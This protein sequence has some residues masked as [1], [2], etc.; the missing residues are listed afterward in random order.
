MHFEQLTTAANQTHGQELKH[1]DRQR[2]VKQ[3]HAMTEPTF[4]PTGAVLSPAEKQQKA[5]TRVL[6]YVMADRPWLNGYIRHPDVERKLSRFEW[7]PD[8]YALAEAYKFARPVDAII[9]AR[10]ELQ[11]L[12]QNPQ[13]KGKEKA[14]EREY[15]FDDIEVIYVPG[16]VSSDATNAINRNE[17]YTI[18]VESVAWQLENHMCKPMTRPWDKAA[19]ILHTTDPDELRE[20]QRHGHGIIDFAPHLLDNDNISLLIV[21]LIVP[22]SDIC[23]R[24]ADN[25]IRVEGSTMSHRKSELMKHQLGWLTPEDKWGFDTAA[26]DLQKKIRAV[27]APKG[28]GNRPRQYR[29]STAQLLAPA[30]NLAPNGAGVG[31]VMNGGGGS[32][33]APGAGLAGGNPAGFG[34]Y[35]AVG[36]VGGEHYGSGA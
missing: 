36:N 27:C 15:P 12:A 31:G 18:S 6:A 30:G 20:I 28:R 9:K 7:A 3:A 35:F 33:G 17:I 22:R 14:V 11:M 4:Y 29:R 1:E 24:F 23:A 2:L 13:A 8:S 16:T 21:L 5:L 25:G 32:G 19:Q 10:E 34:G 26:S